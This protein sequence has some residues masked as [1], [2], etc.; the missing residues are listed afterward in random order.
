MY[1]DLSTHGC[2]IGVEMPNRCRGA[3]QVL[4]CHG[5]ECQ[6][7]PLGGYTSKYFC[8]EWSFTARLHHERY[9]HTAAILSDGKV[10]VIGGIPSDSIDDEDALHSTEL[11]DPSTGR[12]VA[13]RNMHEARSFHT[14]SLPLNG[15]VLVD[16]GN[17]DEY[18]GMKGSELRVG[19]DVWIS[20][21][22]SHP[23]SHSL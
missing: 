22:S 4:R 11:Y 1:E 7:F 14:E 8:L 17:I 10:L 18:Y 16:G 23:P 9:R 20:L 15:V 5:S 13:T 3:E 2:R 6:H 19:V 21:F 12:W